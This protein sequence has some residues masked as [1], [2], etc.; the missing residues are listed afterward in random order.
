MHLTPPP[1]AA[2]NGEGVDVAKLHKNPIFLPFLRENQCKNG[3][4]N[5]FCLYPFILPAVLPVC[6]IC[7]GVWAVHASHVF[8]RELQNPVGKGVGIHAF[9]VFL[10]LLGRAGAYEYGG[11]GL[12]V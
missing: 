7:G 8:H 3:N 5:G 2:K 10:Q 9:K 6:W 1:R 12:L 4:F 11:Y